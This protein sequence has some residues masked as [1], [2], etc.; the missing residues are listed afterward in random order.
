MFDDVAAR[1][2]LV[3]D[4]L[5]LGQD[6]IWRKAVA[7]AVAGTRRRGTPAP[8]NAGLTDGPG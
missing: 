5:S 3:N 7:R 1:Y 6:R 8:R 4:V 2:D